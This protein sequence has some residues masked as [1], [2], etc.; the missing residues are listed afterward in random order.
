MVPGIG[1]SADPVLQARMFSYPDA[2][3]Y[4]VGPNYFQLPPNRPHNKVYAPYVRD[5]PGTMNGNYGGDPDYVF[6]ELRPVRASRRVQLPT[7]EHFAGE[8][9]SFATQFTDKDFGQAR[10]LWKII[11]SEEDGEAQF[12]HSILPTLTDLPDGLKKDVL[13][14]FS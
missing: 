9:T 14:T 6:S 10:Q 13:S 4:R 5:G 1:P 12:L 2:H 8:V 7:H 11:C 3:R